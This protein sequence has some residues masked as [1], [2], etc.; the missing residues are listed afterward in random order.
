MMI[1]ASTVEND[2]IAPTLLWDGQYASKCGRASTGGRWRGDTFQPGGVEEYFALLP[3][4]C[5][6]AWRWGTTC[7]GLESS[8]VSIL[9]FLFLKE[10]KRR[11]G[12]FGFSPELS[13]EKE[14]REEK[15]VGGFCAANLVL[16]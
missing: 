8:C 9:F 6:W 5:S 7:T 1:C 2:I 11:D 13:E 16:R 15:K 14:E 4:P 10:R 3:F 12:D